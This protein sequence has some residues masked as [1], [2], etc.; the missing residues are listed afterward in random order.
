MSSEVHIPYSTRHI[1][2]KLALVNEGNWD[3]IYDDIKTKRRFKDKELE[4][5]A[6]TNYNFLSII[7][8]KYPEKLKMVCRPPFVLFYDGNIELLNESNRV[9]SILN[10]HLASSYACEAIF[11]ICKDLT[12]QYTF[13]IEF[14]SAKNNELIT[15]LLSKGAR[16]IAVLDR[17]IGIDNS[18]DKE[19]YELLRKEQLILTTFPGTVSKKSTSTL[20]ESSKLLASLGTSILI[21]GI[22]DRS[23]QVCVLPFALG[24][25]K[26]VYCIPFQMGTNYVNN[27]L[28]HDG[29]TI[30]VDSGTII[31]GDDD[32]GYC[33]E[34][35]SN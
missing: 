14:G 6:R 28:I 1:L 29:A 19:L 4:E 24:L 15:K 18:K 21:G 3:K 30:V 32:T 23:P 9:L 13:A 10:E 12:E 7:D 33:E 2:L 16:V 31:S 26:K 11:N 17:G 8:E 27:Q 20:F 25:N 22:T 5:V 35:T 34:A